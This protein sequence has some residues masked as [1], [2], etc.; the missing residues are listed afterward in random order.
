MRGAVGLATLNRRNIMPTPHAEPVT[1]ALRLGASALLLT[2]LLAGCAPGG[3]PVTD[4]SAQADPVE[5][6][7]EPSDGMDNE[8][9]V[10]N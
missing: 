6:I 5:R 7:A 3:G 9:D 2:A 8:I 1:N 10:E 4:P